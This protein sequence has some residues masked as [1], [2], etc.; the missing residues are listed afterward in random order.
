MLVNEHRGLSFRSLEIMI[1]CVCL[2]W[3]SPPK[4]RV[5][6]VNVLSSG[7]LRFLDVW[8]QRGSWMAGAGHIRLKIQKYLT[9]FCFFSR[10]PKNFPVSPENLFN[11]WWLFW[12]ITILPFFLQNWV[13]GCPLQVE[14]PGPLHH[15]HPPLMLSLNCANLSTY[16]LFDKDTVLD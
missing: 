2:L 4:L 9:F 8:G 10:L 16:R 5:L 15:P 12:S 14:C 7:V 11:F 3:S 1:F 6:I 13:V